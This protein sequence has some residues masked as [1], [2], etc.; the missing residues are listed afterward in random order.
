MTINADLVNILN[1]G[2]YME[3]KPVSRAYMAYPHNEAQLN[4][5]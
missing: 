3:N 5:P 4:T 2:M 1:K